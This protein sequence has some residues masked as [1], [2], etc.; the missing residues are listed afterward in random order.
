VN[1]KQVDPVAM[2]TTYVDE[3]FGK[4]AGERHAHFLERIEN[5]GLREMMYRYHGLEADQHTLSREE[6]YLLGVAV[7]CALGRYGT[8]GMFAKTLRH[9]GT[10]RAKVL[11]AVARTAMWV[12]GIPATEASFHI[13]RAL[14]E[15]DARGVASL[16]GW[17]D[18][19]SK[20][21]LK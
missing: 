2:T 9:L 10:P 1:A 18:P 7:L 17:F 15:Y 12:G 6:N 4:G 14:D 20:P 21:P 5:E 3:L 13:Q 16:E 8:A 11:E 19:P